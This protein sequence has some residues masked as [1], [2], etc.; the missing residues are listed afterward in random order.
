MFIYNVRLLLDKILSVQLNC[1]LLFAVYLYTQLLLSPVSFGYSCLLQLYI[2]PMEMPNI[3]QYLSSSRA[4]CEKV[5]P[6]KYCHRIFAAKHCCVPVR[7]MRHFI[8]ICTGRSA[9]AHGAFQVNVAGLSI[10]IGRG[11][12]IISGG[13]SVCSV[14]KSAEKHNHFISF[15]PS[16][17]T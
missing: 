1:S 17:W 9:M 8:C 7:H 11:Y 10:V 5:C 6:G 15:L 14:I 3:W 12:R 4:P 2:W 13:P 16:D